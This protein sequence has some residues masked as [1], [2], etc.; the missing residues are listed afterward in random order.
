[1]DNAPAHLPGLADEMMEELEFITVQFLPPNTTPVIEPM[2]RQVISNFK[3]LYNKAHFQRSL[4]VNS[5]TELTF[6]D[7]WKHHFNIL[8]CITFVDKAW[9]QVNYR[10]M[11]SA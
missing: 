7:F 5:D 6:R 4:E 8:H 2:D 10:T 3:K 11:N 9:Q 1:M